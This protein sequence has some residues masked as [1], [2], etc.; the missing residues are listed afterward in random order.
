MQK[1]KGGGQTRLSA[2]II[3]A[4]PNL[5]LLAEGGDYNSYYKNPEKE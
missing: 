3:T 5:I 4:A 2:C 1:N